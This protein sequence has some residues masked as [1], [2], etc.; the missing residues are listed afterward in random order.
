LLEGEIGE[1]TGNIQINNLQEVVSNI[2]IIIYYE[3]NIEP[4]EVGCG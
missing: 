1:H 3:A 4:A 2:D